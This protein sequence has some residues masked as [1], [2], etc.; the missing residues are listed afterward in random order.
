MLHQLN[1]Q[2]NMSF[3]MKKDALFDLESKI[4]ELRVQLAEQQRLIDNRI[5]WESAMLLELN[6]FYRRRAEI[7][8]QYSKDL[9][10][11]FQSRVEKLRLLERTRCVTGADAYSL[12][13]FYNTVLGIT[14]S[15]S[16]NH[17]VVAKIFSTKMAPRFIDIRDNSAKLL[18]KCHE[19]CAASQEELLDNSKQVVQALKNY[20]IARSHAAQAEAK[21]TA[22]RDERRRIEEASG[23]SSSGG[24]ACGPQ[25][26][27]L[28]QVD[29]NIE[30]RRDKHEVTHQKALRERNEYLL[31]L[32]S[33]NACIRR[34]FSDDLSDILDC[35]ACG[36]HN[37][38]ARAAMMHLN[39]EETLKQRQEGFVRYFMNTMNQLDAKQDK[40]H[41]LQSS[42]SVFTEPK[43]FQFEAHKSDPVSHVCASQPD[44]LKELEERYSNLRNRIKDTS[45]EADELWKT[46]EAAEQSWLVHINVPDFYVHDM[47]SRSAKEAVAAGALDCGQSGQ[48]QP[49][50]END[51]KRAWE[52]GEF[53]LSK[54]D[55]Y[56]RKNGHL[57]R[58]HAKAGAISRALSQERG[59]APPPLPTK[60]RRKSIIRVNAQ[61]IGGGRPRLFGGSVEDQV[62][63]PVVVLSCVRLINQFGLFHQG[64]F[65]V[66]GS[67]SDV[68][69]LKEAFERGEDPFAGAVDGRDVNAAAGVLKCY[70][71]DLEEPVFPQRLFE[72]LM[73]CVKKDSVTESIVR[74]R[75]IFLHLSP[76]CYRVLRFI[77]AFLNHL[78]QFAD[79]NLMDSYNLSICL[80]PSFLPVPPNR[81]PVIYQGSITH[82]MKLIIE[83]ESDIFVRKDVP[84]PIY[85]KRMEDD[86]DVEDEEEQSVCSEME[87]ESGYMVAA[88][89]SFEART[90]RE[91]SFNKGD[92]LTVVSR[93]T[94]EWL[95]VVNASG[96]EGL[97]PDAYVARLR[98]SSTESEAL[99]A[100][101]QQPQLQQPQQPEQQHPQS[102][103]HSQH[104]HQTPQCPSAA[105]KATH[106][107]QIVPSNVEN[108]KTPSA[109]TVGSTEQAPKDVS[110]ISSDTI[111]QTAQ[112]APKSVPQTATVSMPQAE[113]TSQT[114]A[115][116]IS[117]LTDATGNI[118][119]TNHQSAS[120]SSTTVTSKAPPAQQKA[121]PAVET[122]V[123]TASTSSI[124]PSSPSSTVASASAA[125]SDQDMQSIDQALQEVI[126]GLELLTYD[127][128]SPYADPQALLTAKVQLPAA[129]RAP[130]LVSDLPES[131]ADRFA[132]E[133]HAD[134]LRVRRWPEPPQSTLVTAGSSPPV[135]AESGAASS[136]VVAPAELPGS[137]PLSASGTPVKPP[138][139]APKPKFC[140]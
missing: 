19:M 36:F 130:D 24:A 88:K 127:T 53:Y 103:L 23:V 110:Q 96:K 75:E 82:L 139:V 111:L 13:K 7:E 78:S 84:G 105:P 113:P 121:T 99:A 120:S 32:E 10:K 63:M 58:L 38:L 52:N 6:E 115:K 123:S 2:L 43:A 47:F 77:F 18:S 118:S 79:E 129:K 42:K 45:V 33:A 16:A 34:Y 124:S 101:T 11:L 26:K 49:V 108:S 87:P 62:E 134:T 90:S 131:A 107:S 41:F 59:S 70:L 67:Q 40:L 106:P 116:S 76:S 83:H 48:Q 72:D 112:T 125:S 4:K 97:I 54:F 74:L 92:V 37:S 69:R 12:F 114:F 81:D 3:K 20:Q 133:G 89:Y 104:Q 44:V 57:T 17:S 126:A 95:R 15:Q 5:E 50:Q 71:R 27:R 60:P 29:K 93:L 31:Q 68:N 25:D 51:K 30:K 35:L 117:S 128:E 132:L 140:K 86:F 66:P 61:L 135:V 85:R 119:P 109:A 64:V 102:Q 91:L 94:A 80:A 55:E 136:A 122:A 73:D 9:K 8:E 14:H 100:N 39:T 65:R 28:K 21:L 137:A 1:P 22:V 138:K 46:L 56:L 98:H